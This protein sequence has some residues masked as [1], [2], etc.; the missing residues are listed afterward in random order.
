MTNSANKRPNI[1]ANKVKKNNKKNEVS[2]DGLT[3]GV[4]ENRWRERHKLCVR[5]GGG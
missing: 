2:A 4:T 5:E 1:H 3:R